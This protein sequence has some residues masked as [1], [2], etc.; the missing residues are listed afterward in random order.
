MYLKVLHECISENILATVN[1]SADLPDI[2]TFER[3]CLCKFIEQQSKILNVKNI[4]L[5]K[6]QYGTENYADSE[7]I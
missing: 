3:N 2:K 5:R 6:K 4:N 7:Y 1:F